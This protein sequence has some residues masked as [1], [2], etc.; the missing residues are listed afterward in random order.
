MSDVEGFKRWLEDDPRTMYDFNWD[1]WAGCATYVTTDTSYRSGPSNDLT[2]ICVEATVC[3]P[4][5]PF[6]NESGELE[7]EGLYSNQPSEEYYKGV[8]HWWHPN[9]RYNRES[10]ECLIEDKIWGYTRRDDDESVYLGSHEIHL[11]P[12]DIIRCLDGPGINATDTE[13]Y[14]KDA[15]RE[16]ARIDKAYGDLP[17]VDSWNG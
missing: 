13:F 4:L 3:R 8:P 15:A 2:L 7:W 5:L 12:G 17:V 11:E 9:M 10:A 16:L 1:D 14:G 6:I